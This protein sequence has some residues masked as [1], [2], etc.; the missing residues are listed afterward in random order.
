MMETAISRLWRE[1][2]D[3]RSERVLALA[4]R[5]WG[6]WPDRAVGEW[7]IERRLIADLHPG[8]TREEAD[9][10]A[11]SRVR[12]GFTTSRGLLLSEYK[13]RVQEGAKSAARSR[14]ATAA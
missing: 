12:V 9:W 5:E 4:A 3:F 14:G 13:G 6:A 7:N 2:L 8:L 1:V 11:W 10:L